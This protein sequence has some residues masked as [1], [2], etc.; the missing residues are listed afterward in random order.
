MHTC[1]LAGMLFICAKIDL[2]L[3]SFSII[4]L[5]IN[6]ASF[7]VAECKC[8]SFRY[9]VYIKVLV[10]CYFFVF[11]FLYCFCKLCE[12]FLILLIWKIAMFL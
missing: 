9:G 1:L 4:A 12:T 10:S 11:R 6:E 5:I 3:A 7:F 8:A 2:E